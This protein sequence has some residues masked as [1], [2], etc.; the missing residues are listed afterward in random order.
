M[1]CLMEHVDVWKGVHAGAVTPGQPN[2]AALS[3]IPD[4]QLPEKEVSTAIS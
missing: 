4:T 1:L 3:P 2:W